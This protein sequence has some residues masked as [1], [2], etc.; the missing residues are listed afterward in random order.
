M[1]LREHIRRRVLKMLG[2]VKYDTAPDSDRLTFINDSESVT[3]MK[4]REYNVW[5]DGDGD[6]LLNFYTRANVIDF[7][8][9]PFYMRNK[10]NYFW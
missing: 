9:E 3:K 4:L 1:T 8:Y 5:Y 2:L 7:N 6:E 10:K